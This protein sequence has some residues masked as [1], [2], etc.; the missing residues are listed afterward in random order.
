MFTKTKLITVGLKL[1]LQTLIRSLVNHHKYI[2]FCSVFFIRLNR[3]A[4]EDIEINGVQIK[5]G[6]DCTFSTEALHYMSEYWEEP[7]KFMP[8]RSL[9]LLLYAKQTKN[10][11]TK[12]AYQE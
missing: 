4:L 2:Y 10:Y 5:K 12:Y 9:Y 6:M 3:E 8:E 7:K 1:F 11:V